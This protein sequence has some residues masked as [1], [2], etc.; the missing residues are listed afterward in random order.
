MPRAF[1]FGEEPAVT[2]KNLESELLRLT[3]ISTRLG[4][5][6]E[7]LRNELENS[8]KNSSALESRL[9]ESK[10]ELEMLRIELEAL[11]T[12]STELK[13]HVEISLE[14]SA[15]LKDSLQKTESSLKS[16]E[17]SFSEYKQAAEQELNR[18]EQSRNRYR[19]LVIIAG[20]LALSGWAAFS[21]SLLF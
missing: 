19:L 20:T 15:Q 16:L 9:T 3:E 14:E 1:I 5:L 11:Q 6:N 4:K 2:G 10:T 12:S 18:L 21:L 7:M 13:Q 17:Q 8:R